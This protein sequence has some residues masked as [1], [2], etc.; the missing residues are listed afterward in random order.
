MYTE[1]IQR[2]E[3]LLNASPATYTVQALEQLANLRTRAAL[4]AWKRH[5]ADGGAPP[6]PDPA[7]VIRAAVTD[8]ENLPGGEPI[9]GERRSLI[10]SAYKR[11]SQITGGEARVAALRSMEEAYRT[12]F[13]DEE[14][15]R[16]RV[17]FYP[18]LNWLSAH[19]LLS[20]SGVDDPL[21]DFAGLLARAEAAATEQEK[22]GP[23]F[24][25]RTAMGEVILVRALAR[26]EVD[27]HAKEILAHF[28]AAWNTGGSVRRLLS[29]LEHLDWIIAILAGGRKTTK[30][31]ATLRS[32]HDI[33]DNLRAEL[34]PGP[35]DH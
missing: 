25:S 2:Y 29:V 10:G 1:A 26:L 27:P 11:L 7:V 22:D 33:Y 20:Q 6:D 15:R 5:A 23:D 12:A 24:W 4:A 28:R 31:A 8:L 34:T 16:G 21:D 17:D 32:L 9:S 13:R 14:D 3:A 30:R 18:L 19:V 35:F